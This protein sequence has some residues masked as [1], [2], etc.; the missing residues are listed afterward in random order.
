[1]QKLELP[2]PSAAEK[3][4][5]NKLT[6]LIRQRIDEAGGWIPF[7]AYMQMA[8][9]TP[10]LGYY[11]G[12]QQKFGEQGDFITS[13]EVSPL[14]ARSLAQPVAKLLN[15]IPGGKIIEFGAGSGKL[16]L[17]LLKEL[18]TLEQLPDRYYIVELSAEL[19]LRQREYIESRAPELV[20]CVQW[21]TALPEKSLD[22]VVIANE[23]LDAMP[24]KRFSYQDVQLMQLGIACRNNTL[25]LEYK[26]ADENL[27]TKVNE[28]DIEVIKQASAGINAQQH[29]KYASEI[30]CYISPWISALSNCINTGAVYIIDYGY[31]EREYYSA[32][33][34]MGTFMGYFRHRA[35]DAPLWYP[36]LQ[37]LTAFVNFTAVAEAA[38]KND[39]DVDGFTSQGNFLINCGLADILEQTETASNREYLMLAQQMKTLSLPGEMGERFKVL[40]LSKGLDDNMPG[41]E[42]RDMRYSL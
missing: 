20:T 6:E 11:S 31:V 36:G 25:Q 7:D 17:E 4:Q 15:K 12:G 41:F 5:S 10:G 34:N 19:Q 23:V 1:M 2:E 28:L 29:A 33:R 24:V 42:L 21:L 32:E 8:L 30:N 27:Q 9:Y 26:N 16:A 35:I 13:P 39:F 18:Q 22:A 3:N 14:F 40:G 37:D 38:L